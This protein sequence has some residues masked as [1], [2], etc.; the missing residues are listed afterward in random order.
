MAAGH[1]REPFM[2]T[3]QISVGVAAPVLAERLIGM[4]C[5]PMW[6]HIDGIR[7]FCGFFTRTSFSSADLG[8]RVALVIHELVENALK[9]SVPTDSAELD[10]TIFCAGRQIEVSVAN[11]PKPAD[12]ARLL[13]AVNALRR[14]AP[15]QAYLEAMR[16]PRGELD[17]RSGLGLARI[18]FEGRM[19][20]EL[21]IDGGLARMTA[22][23]EL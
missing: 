12:L 16:Q 11:S 17:G 3:N 20:L 15:D 22:K 6:K 10:V 7:Q 19:E 5:R 21:V 2:H 4:R 1:A 14:K 18:R 9:Y 13:E 8:D 23:G